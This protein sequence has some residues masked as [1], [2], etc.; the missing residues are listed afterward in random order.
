M[1]V[2]C[3]EVLKVNV[4]IF[5]VQLRRAILAHDVLYKTDVIAG[6]DFTWHDVLVFATTL[7]NSFC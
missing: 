1:L 3:R 5:V 7:F 2:P 4:V 6:K